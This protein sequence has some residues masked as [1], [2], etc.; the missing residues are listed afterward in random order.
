LFVGLVSYFRQHQPARPAVGATA[1]HHHHPPSRR[2]VLAPARASSRQL[3][4]PPPP[5]TFYH[6]CHSRLALA[7]SGTIH[8]HLKRLHRSGWR[9]GAS[10]KRAGAKRAAKRAATFF[11]FTC[12]RVERKVRFVTYHR[13][14]S[15][16][17]P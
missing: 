10:T 15:R 5:T 1:A 8:R 14:G 6:L 3:A 17:P 7:T 12:S 11:E 2:R 13:L 4:P 16:E 9:V